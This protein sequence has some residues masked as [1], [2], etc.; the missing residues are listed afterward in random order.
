MHIDL[1]PFKDEILRRAKHR[2][3][4]AKQNHPETARLWRKDPDLPGVMG[5][6]TFALVTHRKCPPDGDTVFDGGWDFWCGR[7]GVDTKGRPSP[8]RDMLYEV[9]ASYRA[10]WYVVVEVNEKEWWGELV[11]CCTRGMLQD[12]DLAPDHITR[13]SVPAKIVVESRLLPIPWWMHKGPHDEEPSQC[14]P[15]SH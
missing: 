7:S 13:N 12:A 3:A 2:T 8:W 11:G 15:R 5:E 4:V 1:S 14:E 9:S 10:D 6:V